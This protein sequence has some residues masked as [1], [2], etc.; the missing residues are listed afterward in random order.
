MKSIYTLILATAFLVVGCSGPSEK[1]S[2]NVNIVLEEPPHDYLFMQRA[3]PFGDIQT[4]AY[5]KA[6][7]GNA[8][9]RT[10]Q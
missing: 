10:E 7:N 8:I 1:N 5:A 6:K 9:N 4:D 2:E 3:Y